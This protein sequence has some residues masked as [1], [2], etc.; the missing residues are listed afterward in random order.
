MIF[1]LPGALPGA[2]FPLKS[3]FT[4][5]KVQ[6]QDFPYPFLRSHPS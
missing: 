1:S 3:I 5:F 6:T 4:L 2:A